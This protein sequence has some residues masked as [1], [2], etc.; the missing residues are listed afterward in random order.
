M[1]CSRRAA[2]L[3]VDDFIDAVNAAHKLDIN[4][5]LSIEEWLSINE[6]WK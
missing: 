1:G 4:L 6:E 2:H 3:A 5:S